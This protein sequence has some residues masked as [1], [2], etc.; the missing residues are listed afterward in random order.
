[1]TATAEQRERWRSKW[2]A[3]LHRER[4]IA[5]ECT[6]EFFQE[7]RAALEAAI[8]GDDPAPETLKLL[9]RYPH[10]LEGLLMDKRI[11]D[12]KTRANHERQVHGARKSRW[13]ADGTYTPRNRKAIREADLLA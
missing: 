13:A 7:R 11:R 5:L 4:D 12:T 8:L 3:K 1:M 6:L 9:K 10:D 2:R